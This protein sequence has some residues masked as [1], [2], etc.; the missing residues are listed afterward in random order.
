MG[1]YEIVLK[2]SQ[3]YRCKR[4]NFENPH[5][6]DGWYHRVSLSLI[7]EETYSKWEIRCHSYFAYKKLKVK[8]SRYIEL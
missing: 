2:T 1:K 8:S 5:L 3:S 4:V 6:H 7:N